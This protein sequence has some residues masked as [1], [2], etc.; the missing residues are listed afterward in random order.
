MINESDHMQQSH[1][2]LCDASVEALTREVRRGSKGLN[3]RFRS[4]GALHP[5][6]GIERGYSVRQSP[7][8]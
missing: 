8:G 7:A 1:A 2:K 4:S 6:P 3:L 5:Y